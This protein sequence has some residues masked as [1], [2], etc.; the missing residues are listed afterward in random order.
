MK[1]SINSDGKNSCSNWRLIV[2]I[3]FIAKLTFQSFSPT[4]NPD[5]NKGASSGSRVL[6]VSD[7]EKLLFHKPHG[8]HPMKRITIKQI[9]DAL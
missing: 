2:S 9:I 1:Y 3:T 5:P 7:S 6:F 4:F 8:D